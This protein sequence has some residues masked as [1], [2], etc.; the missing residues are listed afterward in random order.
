[1]NVSFKIT[2]IL[3]GLV[4]FL[5]TACKEAAPGIESIEPTFGLTHGGE[6]VVIQ[7]NNIEALM[8]VS[9]YF[10]NQR[11][12]LYQLHTPDELWITSPAS[13]T[14]KRVDVRI[15]G[16]DGT[17]FLMRQA[18]NYVTEANMAEC[19]NISKQLNGHPVLDRTSKRE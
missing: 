19:V 1:M 16:N 13:D 6:K 3:L 4:I 11:V 7:G 10:G 17:E 2:S 15:I 9:V 14:A 18:F 5:V 12:Y 8:P